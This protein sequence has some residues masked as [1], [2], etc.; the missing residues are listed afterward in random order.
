[1]PN[2]FEIKDVCHLPKSYLPFSD[3]IK[4]YYCVNLIHN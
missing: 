2:L 1:M 4:V 3:K